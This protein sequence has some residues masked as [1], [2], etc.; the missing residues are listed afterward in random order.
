MVN[1]IESA[2][3]LTWALQCS[4]CR[5]VCRL[6]SSVSP[7][8]SAFDLAQERSKAA[9]IFSIEGW[10]DEDGE[11]LCPLCSEIGSGGRTDHAEAGRW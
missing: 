7:G 2:V 10:D 4:Y 1:K 5:A 9:T 3:V 11:L 8:V 6:D